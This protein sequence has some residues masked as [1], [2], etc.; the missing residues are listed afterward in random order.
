MFFK[1]TRFKIMLWYIIIL[2]L[3]L[4]AFSLLLYGNFSNII[5]GDLDDLLVAKAEGVANS[6]ST[7]IRIKEIESAQ[8][9][10]L[11]GAA[12]GGGRENFVKVAR[13]WV[14]TKTKDPEL[15]GIFTRIIDPAQEVIV[16]S[17]L[18]PHVSPLPK[19]DFDDVLSGEDSFDELPGES[20]DGKKIRFS[21]YTK[22]VIEDGRAVYIVQVVGSTGLLS[23]ALANLRFVLFVLFPLTILLACI[24]G[25]FLVKIALNPIDK[26]IS[27]LKR[28]TAENLKLRIHIP[29]TKDEMKRLADTFNDMLERLD[30]SFGSQQKFIEG[31]SEELRMPLTILEKDVRTAL[32]KARTGGEYETLLRNNLKE[33]GGFSEIIENLRVLSQLDSGQI[34][35]KITKVDLAGLLEDIMGSIRPLAGE[36]GIDLASYC[37]DKVILDGD[38]GQLTTLLAN[39]LDNAVKYTHRNGR[40]VVTLEKVAKFA[41]I[42]VSDTGVGIPE[43]E[44]D[45]IFDKFYQV[46]KSRSSRNGFGLGLSIARTIV[47]EHKGSIS[48]TSRVGQGSVFIISLPLLYPG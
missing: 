18:M 20:A 41:K 28:I 17:R 13:D 24:P 6:I 39:I 10:Q 5:Y 37:Q 32:E 22:P 2:T 47:E 3:T 11:S 16:S 45:Y 23:I 1:S 21:V 7:Y 43:E 15:M 29:D 31:I 36:K 8:N 35:L 42:T 19:E 30:R 33:I 26:M 25:I 14:D 34:L 44:L 38:S 27:T 12:G 46:K 9:E 48:A 4:S 40:I